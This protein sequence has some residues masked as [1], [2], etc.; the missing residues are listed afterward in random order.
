[1]RL[2]GALARRLDTGRCHRRAVGKERFALVCSRERRIPPCR[3]R[4]IGNNA[5]EF[6]HLRRRDTV[7][8]EEDA[9]VLDG[10][11]GE[12][13]RCEVASKSAAISDARLPRREKPHADLVARNIGTKRKRVRDEM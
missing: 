2:L 8:D 12:T 9:A 6:T 5:V 11:H 3:F 13:N 7:E 1:M 10:G 4:F